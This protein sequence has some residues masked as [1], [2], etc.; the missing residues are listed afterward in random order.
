MKSFAISL[1]AFA[2]WLQLSPA[3]LSQMMSGKRPVT[4]TMMQKIA[5]RLGLSPA[6]RLHYMKASLPD[7]VEG[8]NSAA[9][10]D[11][12]VALPEDRFRLIA[13]WYH[14]AIL[15][16][17]QVSGSQ[18][19]PRW[20]ARR[21]GISQT[22]AREALDRLVRLNLIQL[23]PHFKSVGDPLRV[24]SEVSSEAIRKFHKQTLALAMEKMDTVETA[25]REFQAMT[26][27]VNV[28][29]LPIARKL[30]D[31][32]LTKISN[33]LETGAASEVYTL[34]VQLFPVTQIKGESKS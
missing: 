26:M 24:S 31:E 21:L 12:S 23:K 2:R 13:D 1:R 8:A 7:W 25:L 4:L 30:I 19:D 20:I 28:N 22:Q 33:A 3:Q 9:A 6:E 18:G 14:F 10:S 29:K 32:A 34:S 5:N 27:A 17:S 16:L 11:S 15:S